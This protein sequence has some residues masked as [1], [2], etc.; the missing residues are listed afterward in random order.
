MHKKKKEIIL[1]LLPFGRLCSLT[2]RAALVLQW[3]LCHKV[4]N[5]LT[6]VYMYKR[7]NIAYFAPLAEN[8]YDS[9]SASEDHLT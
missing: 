7:R 2:H 1:F 6:F 9:F 8:T 5:K 4:V 3:A